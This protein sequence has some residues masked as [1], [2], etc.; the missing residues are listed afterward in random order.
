MS[1][2]RR[3]GMRGAAAS[4]AVLLALGLIAFYVLT[5]PRTVDA[6]AI[7]SHTPDVD[8]GAYVFNAGGCSSC[9]AAPPPGAA[10]T[11]PETP[12]PLNLSG[13]RCLV[14]PFGTFHV[15]NITPDPQ[16]GIGGW[17][18]QEFLNAML[19]GVSPSGAHYYP[20]FPY[21]SY[22][23]MRPQDALDL[24]AYLDTL[25]A[26]NAQARAH[27]LA[28]PFRLRRGLGLWKL[29]YLDGKPF[30]DDP[31]RSPEVNRGAY[32]VEALSH[33]G[34]CHTPRTLLGGLDRSRW[35]AGA[36]DPEGKGYVPNITPHADGIG[37]WSEA[38]IVELLTSGFTPEFDSVGGTMA[39]VVEHTAKLTPEDR[40][41]IAA[42]L[43]A[44]PPLPS[45][46]RKSD[47]AGAS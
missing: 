14:T 28:M 41:A 20:A 9:H 3:R 2:G 22:Q 15:P 11:D 38:D 35:L 46:R 30:T 47:G 27:D 36:P 26:V 5:V 39:K 37:S 4:A 13:G 7:P 16:T 29:L 19:R 34:E 45:E 23:R 43:K 40:K 18:D 8:N 10:C 21:T 17:S 44:I 6:A 31:A 24:K 25:P 12:D 33:C 1:A 32:L 42:Y